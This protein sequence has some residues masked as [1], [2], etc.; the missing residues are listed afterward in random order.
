MEPI[1]KR[2]ALYPQGFFRITCLAEYVNRMPKS[3][4]SKETIRLLLKA[5]HGKWNEA[6]NLDE[7]FSFDQTIIETALKQ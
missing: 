1:L 2:K 5:H 6:M 4:F 7:S 3:D